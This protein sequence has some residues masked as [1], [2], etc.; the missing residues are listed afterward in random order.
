MP[1]SA[2]TS[3]SKTWRPKFRVFVLLFKSRDGSWLEFTRT[4]LRGS[5]NRDLGSSAS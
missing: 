4:L 5:M 1:E 3:R 2:D